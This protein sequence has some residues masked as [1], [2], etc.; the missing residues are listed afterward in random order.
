MEKNV[1]ERRGVKEES[2]GY[3]F[4]WRKME[5]AESR[6]R[7]SA[8]R[9][10]VT[11]RE[12]GWCAQCQEDVQER[13]KPQEVEDGDMLQMTRQDTWRWKKQ[14][15]ER[16]ARREKGQSAES[17]RKKKRLTAMQDNELNET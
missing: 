9:R 2:S 15:K 4:R 5:Q 8:R 3:E 1:A 14:A 6:R 17:T 11:S 16:G 12:G 13:R 7:R 10:L